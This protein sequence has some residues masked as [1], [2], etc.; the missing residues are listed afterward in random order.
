MYVVCHTGCRDLLSGSTASQT[1]DTGLPS[2][3][4]KQAASATVMSFFI[5]NP[6]PCAGAIVNALTLGR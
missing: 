4:R 5:G 1:P 6:F 2:I 3:A